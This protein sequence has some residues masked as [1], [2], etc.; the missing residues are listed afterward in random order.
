MQDPDAAKLSAV[1]E[2][3]EFR[4]LARRVLGASAAPLMPAGEAK[5]ASVAP[6]GPTDAQMDM[7]GGGGDAAAGAASAD[8]GMAS[9]DPEKVD[10]R[11]AN[12]PAD[13]AHVC[14]EVAGVERF[15]FD[16]ETTGLNPLTAELVGIA[17]SWETGKGFYLPFPEN[18]DEAQELIEELRPFF[19]AENIQKIGQ[20]L[21]KKFSEILAYFV[22]FQFL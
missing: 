20:N 15:A 12:T 2:S 1:F 22:N 6:A 19:E 4:T 13:W 17:F 18:K 5:T 9:F 16:T 14:E 7:F 8:S 11:M 10:Y 21:M 3:L